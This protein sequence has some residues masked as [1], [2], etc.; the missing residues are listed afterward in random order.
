MVQRVK[1]CTTF[2][3]LHVT[4]LTILFLPQLFIS[5]DNRFL[6]LNFILTLILFFD[7]TLPFSCLNFRS[8]TYIGQNAFQCNST[9]QNLSHTNDCTI[10]YLYHYSSRRSAKPD[11]TDLLGIY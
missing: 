10:K 11:L 9:K 6:N 5:V 3:L 2:T 8:V 1:I 7:P 4:A